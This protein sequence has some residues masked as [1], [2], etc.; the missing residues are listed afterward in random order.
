MRFWLALALFAVAG[1]G[2]S[3]T[4]DVD[5]ARANYRVV[6]SAP[7]QEQSVSVYHSRGEASPDFP[8][9]AENGCTGYAGVDHG[10]Y[11]INLRDSSG[12][13]LT[14][15]PTNLGL[16]R[17]L[18]VTRASTDGSLSL[19][20]HLDDGA[21][22][23]GTVSLRFINATTDGGG[24]DVQVQG[25][26][27]LTNVGVDLN[28]DENNDLDAANTVASIAADAAIQLV[29]RPTQTADFGSGTNETQL[30]IAALPASTFMTV[31][32]R[33]T[34]TAPVLLLVPPVDSINSTT[35]S[36]VPG[37]PRI[38]VINNVAGDS[39]FG[40]MI[41]LQQTDLQ[42]SVT[43]GT[44][45]ST[46][47]VTLE[48][49]STYVV[50]ASADSASGLTFLVYRDATADG[51][52]RAINATAGTNAPDVTLEGAAIT[53]SDLVFGA[54][55]SQTVSDPASVTGVSMTDTSGTFTYAPAVS[56]S[57]RY[58]VFV[59]D[60]TGALGVTALTVSDGAW[61]G[62]F[63]PKQ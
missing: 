20:Q 62:T 12:A 39:G 15:Y 3:T 36:I 31:V 25:A 9:V 46:L 22:T 11:Y 23:T 41:P 14:E 50:V 43:I 59:G 42:P 51:T 5:K 28:S 44:R 2:A 1:C 52:I 17:Y 48:A 18:Y 26:S 4:T 7:L 37:K 35:T 58:L 56:A 10:S 45:T 38:A 33:G 40:A 8:R 24:I 30:L 54:A 19:S 61:S 47:P 6:V 13:V 57:T 34:S 29:V 27:P 53:Y 16:R 21:A 32:A 63:T 55:V 60:V 49:D